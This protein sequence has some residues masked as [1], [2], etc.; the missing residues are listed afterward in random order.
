VNGWGAAVNYI[1]IQQ[2]PTGTENPLTIKGDLV[3]FPNPTTG[4]FTASYKLRH[5]SQ[6][7]VDV[8]D[9]FG[10]V[11]HTKNIGEKGVGKH[12]EN[13]DLGYQPTGTYLLV[14]RTN[15]GNKIEKFSLRK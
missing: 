15:N 6:V 13:F 2:A 3:V 7:N 8:L 14:L 11:V 9:L 5:A 1:T 12:E 4:T 10:R